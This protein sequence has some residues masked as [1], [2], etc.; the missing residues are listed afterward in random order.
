MVKNGLTYRF[1]VYNHTYSEKRWAGLTGKASH[2]FVAARKERNDKL[3][4]NITLVYVAQSTAGF[5]VVDMFDAL[6]LQPIPYGKTRLENVVVEDK[7][8]IV[9]PEKSGLRVIYD[10]V[11][12]SRMGISAIASG[13]SQ[14][15]LDD[16]LERSAN[17]MVF[18]IPL[19]DY[20]NVR[21][22]IERLRGY[23]AVNRVLK[24]FAGKWMTD[25][26]DVST[27][28][29]LVNSIKVVATECMKLAAD[30][31]ALA[32]G[33]NLLISCPYAMAAHH[34]LVIWSCTGAAVSC[35]DGV[36]VY[37]LGTCI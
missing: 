5:K 8:F 29:A 16:A 4:K 13:M 26:A 24:L 1:R 36:A 2:W 11:F 10:T 34:I 7:H 22:T 20:D 15:L 12:R 30:A 27:D 3:T 25:N 33:G 9:S 31:Q 17:R 35:H 6:G 18:G 21:Y 14:R 23:A 32:S 28:Y 19:S 37:M